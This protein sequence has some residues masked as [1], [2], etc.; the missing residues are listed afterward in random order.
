M[1]IRRK[2]KTDTQKEHNKKI[3]CITV[4]GGAYKERVVV[5]I[6]S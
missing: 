3:K 2:S 5:I 1:P 6:F 4:C